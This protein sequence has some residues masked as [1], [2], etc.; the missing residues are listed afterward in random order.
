MVFLYGL[1]HH[2]C[3]KCLW[4]F[5]DCFFQAIFNHYQNSLAIALKM[6]ALRK[7][8]FQWFWQP[9]VKSRQSSASF[10]APV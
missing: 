3:L 10:D 5:F 4:G 8:E 1:R 7:V 2:T 6:E 9:Y